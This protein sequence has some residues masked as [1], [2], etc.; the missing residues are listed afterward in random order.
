[1]NLC[2]DINAD[3]GPW[4]F[5]RLPQYSVRGVLD[6]MDQWG[7]HRALAGPVQGITYRNCHAAN[8]EL[9][10]ELDAVPGVRERILPAAVLNP[11]YPG[12]L[13]DL[14]ACITSLGCR[15][16]KLYPNYHGYRAWES[17][18]VELCRAA[19]DAGLPV[20]LVVRVEDERFHHWQL[21]VPPTPLE[22]FLKLVEE[23]PGGKFVL[24]GC[25]A[26]E[27]RRCLAEAG[28]GAQVW[29][30]LSY[31]KSPMRATQAI[32]NECGSARL[33]FG[34]HMPFVYPAVNCDKI[35]RADIGAE[36]LAAILGG[37]A[38]AVLGL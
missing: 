28:E 37:N 5:R 29:V 12:A 7:I 33:L 11:R 30:D 27:A 4:A 35:R 24:V 25:N 10:E 22:D 23:V 20:L 19:T 34:T 1:M 16:L 2:V 3:I 13:D 15:A 21:R 6:M 26:A 18:C 17:E 36:D 31:V 8:Q 32:V 14:S 9:A 38:A